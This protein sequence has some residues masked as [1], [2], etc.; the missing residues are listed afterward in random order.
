[1]N[2][3]SFAGSP[4]RLIFSAFRFVAPVDFRFL[5]GQEGCY[6]N[7]WELEVCGADQHLTTTVA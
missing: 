7:R 2:P 6:Q 1:M 5:D 3:S 4:T